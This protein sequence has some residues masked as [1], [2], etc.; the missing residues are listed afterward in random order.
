MLRFPNQHWISNR[1]RVTRVR[2][3]GRHVHATAAWGG[4]SKKRYRR[5][6]NSCVIVVSRAPSCS[7]ESRGG[8]AAVVISLSWPQEFDT[9]AQSRRPDKDRGIKRAN[10]SSST[11]LQY[12]TC[13]QRLTLFFTPAVLSCARSNGRG[14]G[15]TCLVPHGL[16]LSSCAGL[17]AP[18]LET[19]IA[20]SASFGGTNCCEL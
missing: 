15:A 1:A 11:P 16:Q 17:Q 20:C 5:S 3:L 18:D 19:I 6:L 14:V 10:L 2:Y 9:L 7:T 8:Y 4:R 13:V 12:T